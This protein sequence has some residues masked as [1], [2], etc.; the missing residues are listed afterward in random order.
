MEDQWMQEREQGLSQAHKAY[1]NT[2]RDG[3][4]NAFL[5]GSVV[6]SNLVATSKTGGI[7]TVS[8]AVGFE[9]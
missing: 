6:G 3:V 1:F 9:T 8:A 4:C 2:V 7:G 5:A